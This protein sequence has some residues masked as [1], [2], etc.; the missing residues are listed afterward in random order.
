MKMPNKINYSNTFIY[1]T[2]SFHIYGF[3]QMKIYQ[4]VE[5]LMILITWPIIV[6]YSSL[7]LDG[8][9]G[10]IPT[11]HMPLHYALL[12]IIYGLFDDQYT[13]RLFYI[14]FSFLL[15]VFVFKYK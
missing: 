7:N 12:S 6:D 13:V 4:L 2:C 14:F 9:N 15:P 5:Q 8:A 10:H 3:S 1:Y 11:V